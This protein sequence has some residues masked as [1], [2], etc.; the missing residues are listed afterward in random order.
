MNRFNQSRI[1]YIYGPGDTDKFTKESLT[2]LG[3][4]DT[5][6]EYEGTNSIDTDI[7]NKEDG[8][9]FKRGLSIGRKTGHYGNNIFNQD[10]SNCLG[11]K[12][13]SNYIIMIICIVIIIVVI[14]VVCYLKCF[15]SIKLTN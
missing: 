5:N 13:L 6:L 1:P 8:P 12:T 10:Q 2:E 7:Q 3:D 15:E 11:G 9:H 4:D 14:V